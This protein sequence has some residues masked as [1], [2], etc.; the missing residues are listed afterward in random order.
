M[1]TSF[2]MDNKENLNPDTAMKDSINSKLIKNRISTCEDSIMNPSFIEATENS[3]EI[4]NFSFTAIEQACNKSLSDPDS[5][6]H[7]YVEQIRKNNESKNSNI[8]EDTIQENEAIERLIK[9]L[10]IQESKYVSKER[11]SCTKLPNR[12]DRN[13]F[14]DQTQ[15]AD[16]EE[17]SA[18]WE[19][20]VTDNNGKYISPTKMVGLLRPSTILEE[21]S[22]STESNITE[23]SFRTAK[24]PDADQ[25][26]IESDAATSAYETACDSIP[27]DNNANFDNKDNGKKSHG[28]NDIDYG[29]RF[30]ADMEERNSQLFNRFENEKISVENSA[31]YVL[32]EENVAKIYEVEIKQEKSFVQSQ[33]NVELVTIEISDDELDGE[34]KEN[35]LNEGFSIRK[36]EIDNLIE[37]EKTFREQDSREDRE[38]KK[39]EISH[40]LNDTLE[41]VEYIMKLGMQMQKDSAKKLKAVE[42]IKTESSQILNKSPAYLKPKPISPIPSVSPKTNAFSVSTENKTALGKVK[43]MNSPSFA[44]KVFSPKATQNTPPIKN[45]LYGKTLIKQQSAKKTQAITSKDTFKKPTIGSNISKIPAPKVL[46]NARKPFY[47]D[48]ISPVGAYIKKTPVCPTELKIKDMTIKSLDYGQATGKAT[49]Q[50]HPPKRFE[51]KKEN[52]PSLPQKCYKSADYRCVVDERTPLNIPGGEKIHKYLKPALMPAIVRHD[53]KMKM[54][55]P[56]MY[57]H[58][59]NNDNNKTV[60]ST[61]TDL[62]D[63]STISGDVSIYTLRDAQK[64]NF[65]ANGKSMV[66]KK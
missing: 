50:Y 66:S 21:S 27:S 2:K 49:L 44:Q 25:N 51:K 64:F 38:D 34:D 30:A 43:Y 42:N 12:S 22:S 37:T 18:L 33:S 55:S 31:N 3:F 13:T 1:T 23:N 40:E 10:E 15:L 14:A 19:T 7:N 16:I 4:T 61:I 26:N 39:L 32:C 53:G 5:T 62:A 52:G 58:S 17:P 45:S 65:N 9:N 24:K 6:I 56:M 46:S 41:E 60:D 59:R 28:E 29:A 48:V 63:L 20:T 57:N 54:G 8:T 35:E 36:S 47:A 11:T